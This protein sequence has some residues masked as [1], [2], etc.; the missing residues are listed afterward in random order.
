MDFSGRGKV[1]VRLSDK[2]SLTRWKIVYR[3]RYRFPP[4]TQ[5]FLYYRRSSDTSPTAGSIRFRITE[6]HDPTTFRSGTDLLSPT[7]LPWQMPLL[8][9]A[10]APARPSNAP[11]AYELLQRLLLADQLISWDDLEKCAKI[12]NPTDDT[13]VRVW[14]TSRIVQSLD[15]TFSIRFDHNLPSICL[16][17]DGI[18]QSICLYMNWYKCLPNYSSKLIALMYHEKVHLMGNALRFSNLSL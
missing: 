15:D 4:G 6:S 8:V 16:V 2:T 10:Q 9:I 1:A 12:N 17:A 13:P 5:G 11:S 18:T 7:G 14:V 3:N